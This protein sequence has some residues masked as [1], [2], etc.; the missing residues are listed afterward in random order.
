MNEYL[1]SDP[2]LGRF[3]ESFLFENLPATD[4]GLRP[5]YLNEVEFYDIYL[6]IFGKDYGYEDSEGIS[7]NFS[8]DNFNRSSKNHRKG[9]NYISDDPGKLPQRIINTIKVLSKKYLIKTDIKEALQSNEKLTNYIYEN[10]QKNLEIHS[11]GIEILN[12][13]IL[14]IKP[15]KETARALEAKAREEILKRADDAIYER[16]NSSV[17]QERTIKENELKTEIA[18][19]VKKREIRETQLEADEVVQTKQQE[20]KRKSM[21]FEIEQEQ[22]NKTLTQSKVVNEKTIAD[23]KAYSIAAAMK[24]IEGMDSN[25]IDSLANIDMKPEKLIAAAFQGLA[26]NAE[27]IGQLN[28][29]PDLLSGLIDGGSDGA[30]F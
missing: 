6:G 23:A 7:L 10:I 2:L 17:E 9:V 24:A 18:V 26:K 13:S 20:L 21:E 19:E 8:S 5:T 27:K 29:T 28:I 4:Q 11:L 22:E 1:F 14:A 25:V 30:D 12:F 3:F 15:N 16:R